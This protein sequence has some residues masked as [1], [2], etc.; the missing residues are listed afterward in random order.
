MVDIRFFHPMEVRYADLD[1]Q[2]HV[3]NATFLTYFEQAR[4]RYFE[5][6]G[7]FSREESFMDIG[8]IIADIHI[9]YEAPV[10]LGAT[11]RV[12]VRTTRIGNKSI[13]VQQTIVD[14]ANGKLYAD[15][16]VVLVAYDYRAQQTTPV[17]DE[18]RRK[19]TEYEGIERA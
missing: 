17:P 2:G 18:W 1:A 9:R 7:L 11:V 3:N 14:A 15:G 12:G 5:M 8:T 4:V 6:L 10:L 16:T 19:L 13:A